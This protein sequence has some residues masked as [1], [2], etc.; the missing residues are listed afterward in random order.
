MEES[1]IILSRNLH[2]QTQAHTSSICQDL[3]EN[4]SEETGLQQ[5]KEDR[6]KHCKNPLIDYLNVNSLRNK[7]Y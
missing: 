1:K 3:K 7:N 4:L 2:K 5:R 6:L